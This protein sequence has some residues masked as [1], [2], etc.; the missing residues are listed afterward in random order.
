MTRFSWSGKSPTG[1]HGLATSCE[2]IPPVTGVAV[3][4]QRNKVWL[5]GVQCSLAPVSALSSELDQHTPLKTSFPMTGELSAKLKV[6]CRDAG[7]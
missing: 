4:L 1:G 7:L 6:K 2:V 5:S 3:P